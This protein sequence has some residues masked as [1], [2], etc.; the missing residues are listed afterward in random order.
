MKKLNY[1]SKV[2]NVK[3]VIDF[4]FKYDSLLR[5]AP[6]DTMSKERMIE[7]IAILIFAMPPQADKSMIIDWCKKNNIELP[8]LYAK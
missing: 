4:Y 8:W 5:K 7:I 3:A 6:A 2:P 1:N